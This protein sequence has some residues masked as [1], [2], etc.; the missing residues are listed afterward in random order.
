MQDVRNVLVLGGGIAGLTAATAM[1]Q[2]GLRVWL[3]ES[4]H[5]LGG[6]AADWACMATDACT[7]CSACLVQDQIHKVM[8]HPNILVC[9]NAQLKSVSGQPGAYH[10]VVS[11]HSKSPNEIRKSH[12]SAAL[13]L[14]EEK[15]CTVE[16]I[17]LATGLAVYDPSS[18]P[19]LGYGRLE[20]V[21]SISDMDTALRRDELDLVL[22]V[23]D[24]GL[25][26][27]FIQC[28][29]SRDRVNGRGYCSQFCCRA[30]IRLI[31][32]LLYLFPTLHVTVFYIDLQIMSK[33]FEIFYQYAQ[34]RV[35]FVQGVPAEIYIG[36]GDAPLE[37]YGTLPGEE[38]AQPFGFDRLVL[39]TGLGPT[40]TQQQVARTLDLTLDEYGYL[41]G[42]STERGIFYAGACQGPADIQASRRQALAAAGQASRWLQNTT[43]LV[44]AK[45]CAD[46]RGL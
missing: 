5:R 8:V 24:E 17:L 35:C 14:S 38:S 25:R 28:I 10:V 43:S 30:T 33:E 22:P 2:R 45:P 19:L 18:D 11:K 13:L 26:L 36:L 31:N 23:K 3:V 7:R 27:G 29:G 34:D 32:R 46:G 1:A 20:G 41:A 9:L 4:A 37:V 21:L 44:Y 42:Q 15:E 39:A 40:D 6:H 12:Q 16:C